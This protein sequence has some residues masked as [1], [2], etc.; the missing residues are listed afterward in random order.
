MSKFF[1]KSPTDRSL[2]GR[3]TA[4]A[5]PQKGPLPV[6]NAQILETLIMQISCGGRFACSYK[7]MPKA[8]MSVCAIN[9]LCSNHSHHG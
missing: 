7:A 4:G 8:I 5:W 3:G 1:E 2:L 9:P 6:F